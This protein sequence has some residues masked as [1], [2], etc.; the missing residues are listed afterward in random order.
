MKTCRF[1]ERSIVRYLDGEL[2]ARQLPLIEDHL[3]AC[4][5]CRGELAGLRQATALL[6]ESLVASLP[7]EEDRHARLLRATWAVAALRPP[8][9]PFRGLW[10]ELLE[11][12]LAAF[13][14]T[15]LAWLAVAETMSFLELGGETLTFVTYLLPLGLG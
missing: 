3:R 7:P 8:R 4:S 12:P 1:V 10:P 11:D 15:I 6:R 9:S 5:R 2:N 13:A 14:A